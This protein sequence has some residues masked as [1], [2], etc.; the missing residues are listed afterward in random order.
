MATVQIRLPAA[1]SDRAAGAT[2]V[3][4]DASSVGGALTALG[5]R[6]P[7]L[8]RLVFDETGN[9]RPHVHLFVGTRQVR[10]EGGESLADGDELRIV[11]SI[12][13]G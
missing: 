2:S 8:V 6:H 1:L 12:A 13:G 10:A 11:P 5:A 4:V 9:V 3:A 7:D